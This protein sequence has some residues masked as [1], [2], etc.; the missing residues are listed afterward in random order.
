MLT[1]H[2]VSF[3]WLLPGYLVLATLLT[4]PARAED[5]APPAAPAAAQPLGLDQAIATALQFN[6][7]VAQAEQDLSAAQALVTQVRAGSSVVTDLEVV[8]THV[9]KVASFVLPVPAPPPQYVSYETISLGRSQQTQATLTVAKPLYTGGKIPAAVRQS[10]AGA[11]AVSEGLRRTLQ[12]V[13]SDVKQAYY[14][15]L[16]A[17]DLVKV[18]EQTAATVRE[19]LRLA[20]A[21]FEAGTAPRF[22]VLRAE[23]QVADSEQV[24]IQARN[25]LNLAR[26]ALDNAM[27]LPQ[28]QQYEL[29]T[30]FAPPQGEVAPLETLVE[31]A[32]AARPELGQVKAQIDAAGAAADLARADKHPTLGVGWVYNRVFNTSA[33]QVT[34]STLALQAT[35]PIFNGRQTSA[36]VSRARSQQESARALLEQIRQGIALQVRQ[37]YLSLGAARERIAAAAKGVEQAEEAHRIATVRYNAGVSIGVEILD[38]QAA[39]AAARNNHARAVYDYNVALTQLE[40]ATGSWRPAELSATPVAPPPQ[41]PAASPGAEQEQPSS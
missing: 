32:H 24:V 4:R 30:S 29:K 1:L 23:T 17:A 5:T 20:Q 22:D 26:A 7:R 8:N 9:N 21:H 16:L 14:G 33:L 37:A 3:K 40:F 19:H 11:S 12:T 15:V 18:A 10:R 25:G 28:G 13:V 41:R 39:L 2:R 35:W 6:P 34:N 38:A 31:Q 36:A 27:G